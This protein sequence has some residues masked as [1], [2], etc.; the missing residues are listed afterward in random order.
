VKSGFLRP[1]PCR[2]RATRCPAPGPSHALRGSRPP[3]TP[4]LAVKDEGPTGQQHWLGTVVT[5]SDDAERWLLDHA[6][7]YGFVA[8][9][10]E[11]GRRRSRLPRTWRWV[12]GPMTARIRPFVDADDPT[13][14]RIAGERWPTS[15]SP[16]PTF[17]VS[18]TSAGNADV[19]WR[20]AP[21]CVFCRCPVR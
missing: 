14:A 9:P 6:P 13:T 7:D 2:S 19:N 20:G 1:T 15:K 8:S 5:F 10:P 11:A 21:R 3:L 16:E 4:D 17:W 12:G 18:R